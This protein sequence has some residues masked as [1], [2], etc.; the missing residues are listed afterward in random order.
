MTSDS[1]MTALF[2]CYEKM[3]NTVTLNTDNNESTEGMWKS[4]PGLVQYIIV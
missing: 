1:Q 4:E 3:M 2:P